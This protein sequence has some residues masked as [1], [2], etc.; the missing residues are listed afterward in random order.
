MVDGSVGPAA[1]ILPEMNATDR[2]FSAESSRTS[3]RLAFAFLVVALGLNVW[4]VT[5]G[6]HG[7]LSDAHE[8]RQIQTA[9]T[10][11][12][13]FKAT[14]FRLDYETPVLGPPWSIPMEF[15]S[16][17]A[18]VAGL[19][20]VTGW[21]LEQCGRGVSVLFFCA[22]LVA[23]YLILRHSGLSRVAGW[24]AVAAT[25]TAPLY[26]FYARTFLIET[27]ALCFGL[28]FLWGFQQGLAGHRW[29][30]PTV[31]LTAACPPAHSGCGSTPARPA[32]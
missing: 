25:L 23:L 17:Q 4:S 12:Y 14:G 31:A 11:A 15:P 21:P 28:W 19:S 18:A 20:S 32:T 7:S 27:T 24:C 6:W 13:H 29:L 26:A 3:G 16:Y 2:D 9:L 8:F 1:A 10:P 22:G 5:R 30:G